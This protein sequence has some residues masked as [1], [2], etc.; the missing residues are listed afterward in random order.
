MAFD[1][2]KDALEH[3][4]TFHQKLSAFYTDL[5]ESADKERT[6]AML[7]YMS[8]HEDYLADRLSQYEEQVSKNIL[9]SYFKYG[10]ESIKLTPI[11]D[12]EIKPEMDV[13][14]VIAAAMHFDAC[15]IEFYREMMQ[16][17]L[18]EKVHE[19]FENLLDMEQHEKI[20]LSKQFLG[21]RSL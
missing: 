11:S 9:D 21:L 16:R 14:D 19:V 7:N 4:R 15:L 20:E 12:F 17:S 13:D 5:K 6:R 1:Q 10:S 8:Q 3:A 2:T 18:S